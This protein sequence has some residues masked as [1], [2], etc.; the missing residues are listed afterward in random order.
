MLRSFL[1]TRSRPLATLLS[2]GLQTELLDMEAIR[3]M[4]REGIENDLHWSEKKWASNLEML[5]DYILELYGRV[6]GKDYA[7]RLLGRSCKSLHA[8]TRTTLKVLSDPSKHLVRK[9]TKQE[10]KKKEKGITSY[11]TTESHDD[12]S[13]HDGGSTKR[14]LDELDDWADSGEIGI[15]TNEE[16]AA[17]ED[18]SDGSDSNTECSDDDQSQGSNQTV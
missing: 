11:K 13:S 10:A 16:A 15:D 3:S 18:L 6:R 14:D 9:D 4:L 5:I 7:S 8:A 17:Q 12:G 1:K 2:H